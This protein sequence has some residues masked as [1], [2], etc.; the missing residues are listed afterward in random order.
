M[1]VPTGTRLQLVAPG[2]TIQGVAI[3]CDTT[4]QRLRKLNSLP[5]ARSIHERN[6]LVVPLGPAEP[7]PTPKPNLA[8]FRQLARFAIVKV[9]C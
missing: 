6:E 3:R 9:R 4:V 1:A 7:G 5:G 8:E 2:D